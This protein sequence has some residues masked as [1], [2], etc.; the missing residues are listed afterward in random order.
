MCAVEFIGAV[1]G[2]F[3]SFTFSSTLEADDIFLVCVESV[4]KLRLRIW[5]RDWKKLKGD[6]ESS[7]I[8][9]RFNFSRMKSLPAGL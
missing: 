8:T 1:S 4:M 6:Q 7:T 9:L 2:K 3:P 5:K